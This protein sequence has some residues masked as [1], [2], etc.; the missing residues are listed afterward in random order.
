MISAPELAVGDALP[1]GMF[2]PSLPLPVLVVWLRHVGCPFFPEPIGQLREFDKK[3]PGERIAVRFVL[4]G[5]PEK[6]QELSLREGSEGLF[7][8]DEAKETYRK[9]GLG[10][11]DLLKFFKDP[12]L[13]KRRS[14][15]KS[16]GFTTNGVATR[17]QDS[18]QLSGA[19]LVDEA[20]TI[21]WLHRG[22]HPGDLPP[23]SEMLHRGAEFSRSF[24][25]SR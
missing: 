15:V 11:F 12:V 19:A 17:F 8:A 3:N 21:R 25:T 20:G 13:L 10:K 14:E 23:M 5:S 16:S 1:A 18:A 2:Q 4:I 6:A 9:M 22:I 24:A 7:V